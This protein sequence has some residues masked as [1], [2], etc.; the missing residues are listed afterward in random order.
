MI[1]RIKLSKAYK[2]HGL[3]YHVCMCM[4]VRAFVGLT[5]KYVLSKTHSSYLIIFIEHVKAALDIFFSTK[6]MKTNWKFF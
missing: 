3:W 6:P 5:F 1:Q 2:W 4:Y